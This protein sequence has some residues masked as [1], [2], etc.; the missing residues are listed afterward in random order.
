MKKSKKL[1]IIKM[2]ENPCYQ[3]HHV[4]MVK[5]KIFTA[6]TGKKAAR[7]LKEIRKKYPQETPQVTYIPKADTL[8]LCA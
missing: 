4:I 1:K 8:V 7:I 5:N 6:K 2:M 3:G